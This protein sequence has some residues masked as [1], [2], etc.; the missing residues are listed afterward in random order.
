MGAITSTGQLPLVSLKPNQLTYFFE[1]VSNS[2]GNFQKS[3]S[4]KQP[5]SNKPKRQLSSKA[6]KRIKSKIHWLLAFSK[7][8]RVY[9][10]YT[11]KYFSFKINFITLTLPTLQAHR[12]TTIKRECLNQ[13]ITEMKQYHGLK[14]YVW[15]AECQSNGNIHF[16]IASDS[17]IPWFI[18]R[19]VWN[20]QL[21]KL[22]Y[23]ERYHKKFHAMTF[24]DYQAY[25]N[26]IGVNDI[27]KISAAYNY[28]K[29]TNWKDPN[30][31]DIHSTYK[32]KNLA[33]YLSKY[34]AKS[35]L[36]KKKSE[37]YDLK[38]RRIEG[39]NWGCSQSLSRCKSIVDFPE[40]IIN[41]IADYGEKVLK[42]F[43]KVDAYFSCLFFDFSRLPKNLRLYI[44][45]IFLEYKKN[46]DYISGGIVQ[47]NYS[48]LKI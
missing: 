34:M 31:T 46:I 4:L 27:S 48:Q 23:I 38:Y 44:N 16:H 42:C 45:Q 22:G 30:T 33:A 25:M 17:Y 7:T 20:R 26:S 6:I 8:K 3:I 28:G 19:T 39:R 47:R 21:R 1:S 37:D 35:E 43:K 18:I 14:N 40:D 15:R 24:K 2:S 9:N 41:E 29:K 36:K 11:N 10:D 32:I 12:D 5:K 13:F